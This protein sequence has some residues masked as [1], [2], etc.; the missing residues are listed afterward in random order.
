MDE[1]RMNISTLTS[2]ELKKLLILADRAGLYEIVA[3]ITAVFANY[4]YTDF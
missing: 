3:K 4:G 1:E 2:S